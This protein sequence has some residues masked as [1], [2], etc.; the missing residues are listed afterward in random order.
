MIK[1]QQVERE[2]AGGDYDSQKD[3]S[4]VHELNNE[5]E[6]SGRKP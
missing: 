2:S 4:N 1:S 3:Y 6:Q 5:V